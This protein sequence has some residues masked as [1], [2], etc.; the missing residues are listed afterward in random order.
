MLPLN[1][2]RIPDQFRK[3]QALQKAG[4]MAEARTLYESLVAV[5]PKM[6]EAHFHLAQIARQE[7]ARDAA[8]GHLERALAARPGEP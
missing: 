6:A 4:R 7:G 8:I 1:S 3:A 2:A 5:A